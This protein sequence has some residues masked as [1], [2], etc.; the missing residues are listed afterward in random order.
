MRFSLTQPRPSTTATVTYTGADTT[1]LGSW[2]G[3]Y[4]ADGLLIPNDLSNAPGY[5]E[6]DLAD[7][8]TYTWAASSSDPRALQTAS[9]STS[10][11]ASTYYAQSF[12]H[13]FEIHRR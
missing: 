1:T 11:I 2:T 7:A 13:R 9:G 4:G 8:V 10:R 6:V 12:P 5:V 3:H